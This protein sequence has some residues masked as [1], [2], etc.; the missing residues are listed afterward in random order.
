MDNHQSCFI[1]IP[2]M[3]D[4]VQ[5][6]PTRVHYSADSNTNSLSFCIRQIFSQI[7]SSIHKWFILSL[8][9]VS[10]DASN[11]F[12]MEVYSKIWPSNNTVCIRLCHRGSGTIRKCLDINSVWMWSLESP[13]TLCIYLPCPLPLTPSCSD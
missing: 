6:G 11:I 7:Y 5:T 8:Y 10:P 3:R 9:S 12:T 2:V 4:S 1:F 13:Y